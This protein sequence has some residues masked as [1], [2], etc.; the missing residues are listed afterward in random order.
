[1]EEAAVCAAQR[2]APRLHPP[3][4]PPRVIRST[5]HGAPQPAQAP[6]HMSSGMHDRKLAGQRIAPHR[7]HR[8]AR[9]SS[10][11]RCGSGV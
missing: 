10:P 1:V 6:L 7:A 9:C 3:L 4:Q 2:A 5:A 8:L 11:R